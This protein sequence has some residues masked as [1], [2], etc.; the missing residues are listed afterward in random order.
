[1]EQ[2]GL[3]LA[4]TIGV[5]ANAVMLL[6]CLRRQFPPLSMRALGGATGPDAGSRAPP[7]RSRALALN[8]A[9][10]RP[11]TSAPSR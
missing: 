8:L 7:R 1:M 6:F 2:A 5:Y 3:A 9:F 10:C 4:A 11:T